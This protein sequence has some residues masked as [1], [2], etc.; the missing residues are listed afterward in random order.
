MANSARY[1]AKLLLKYEHVQLLNQSL[2]GI[3]QE[4]P[5]VEVHQGSEPVALATL[6]DPPLLDAESAKSHAR[7][8]SLAEELASS[9]TSFHPAPLGDNME[10]VLPDGDSSSL[11]QSFDLITD[12]RLESMLQVRL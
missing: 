6:L 10:I 11:S 7:R 5:I 4:P 9:S 1:W 8:T 12:A 3:S 2:Q